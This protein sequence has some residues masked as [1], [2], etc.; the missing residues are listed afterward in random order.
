M[1]RGNQQAIQSQITQATQQQTAEQKALLA[2]QRKVLDA[3]KQEYRDFKFTNPYANMTNPYAQ[4]V[5]EDLTVNQESAKFQMEQGAQ[6]RANIMSSLRGAAGGSG[7]AGL[8]QSLAGQ[9]TLQARQVSADISQQETANQR[10]TAQGAQQ[11]QTGAAQVQ[12][13][14]MQGAAAVQTAEAG[15]TSTLLGMEMGEMA[16]ARAGVQ[17]AYANQMAGWGAISDMQ[18]AN[19][20]STAGMIGEVVAGAAA[21]KVA[22]ACVPKGIHIDT[23]SGSIAIENVRPGDIVIGYNGDPVKVLQKHEYLEDPTKERFY[24]VKFDNDSVVEVCDM[25]RIRGERSKDITE[26]VVSKE[27]YG[28]VEFSYDLLTEDAGYRMNGIP[29][30]S[31]IEEMAGLIV[32]LKN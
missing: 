25:H 20:A 11:R 17:S 31:M 15:R 3:Q 12:Q 9:G 2:Q 10:L 4:N 21:V 24:K 23:V 7:I 26:N 8:A 5:Y 19:M 13:M 18:N 28:G 27:V 1:G 14:Q 22:M 29:V 32:K 30:N 6:Q 16:G